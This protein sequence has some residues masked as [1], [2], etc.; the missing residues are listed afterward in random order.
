[1]DSTLITSRQAAMTD[2]VGAG[3]TSIA[4]DLIG[5][6]AQFTNLL[7]QKVKQ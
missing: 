5:T 4:S 7:Q 1:M 3:N 6:S 2:T